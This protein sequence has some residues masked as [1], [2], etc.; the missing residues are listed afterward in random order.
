VEEEDNA[1]G[2]VVE[3]FEEGKGDTK[4]GMNSEDTEMV[5]NIEEDDDDSILLCDLDLLLLS[6]SENLANH[7]ETMINRLEKSKQKRNRGVK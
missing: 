7:V 2:D 4:T 6:P 5:G 1:E 3:E